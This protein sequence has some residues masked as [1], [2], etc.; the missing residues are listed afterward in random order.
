MTKDNKRL[1]A[2]FTAFAILAGGALCET[3]I[4]RNYYKVDDSFKNVTKY[5]C[6]NTLLDEV[7]TDIS[8]I[9][10]VDKLETYLDIVEDLNNKN[11]EYQ[12]WIDENGKDIVLD[13]LSWTTKSLVAEA[14]DIP[15]ENINEIEIPSAKKVTGMAFYV[16]YNEQKYMIS[17]NNSSI[18]NTLF[19][20]YQ[21]K[22]TED[23]GISQND[24]YKEAIN[25]SKIANMT[26]LIEKY[27][28][29]ENKTKYKE[30]KKELKRK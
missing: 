27:N 8:L 21:V 22:I 10:K 11:N 17:S 4:S 14:L 28:R 18:S 6:D 1:V 30:A 7:D 25:C 16:T 5:F 19:Y 20:Y 24:I 9:D 15:I 2:G 29:L 23:F 26:G 13:M 12:K 3:K